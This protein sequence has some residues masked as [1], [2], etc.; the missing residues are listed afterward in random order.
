MKSTH[1]EPI[2]HTKLCKLI[3]KEHYI[4]RKS[5]IDNLDENRH[6]PLTLV[7]APAG[8][9]KS[10]TISEWLDHTKTNYCWLSLDDEFNDV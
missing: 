2:L 3:V 6:N 8:Y 7:V 5:I 4:F 9:G 10:V 1:N